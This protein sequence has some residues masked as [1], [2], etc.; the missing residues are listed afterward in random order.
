MLKL[1]F[2]NAT[3]KIVNAKVTV[4]GK[5][6]ASVPFSRT[7]AASDVGTVYVPVVV[8]NETK[9]V[10]DFGAETVTIRDAAVVRVTERFAK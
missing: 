3:D 1:T 4:D 9:I 8:G 10:F 7:G 5:T 6:Y 2:S